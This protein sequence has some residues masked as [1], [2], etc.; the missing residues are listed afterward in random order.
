[1]RGITVL[2]I[3][4]GILVISPI[5]I[6]LL[7]IIIGLVP[8]FNIFLLNILL[9][10]LKLS[11][12]IAIIIIIIGLI[13]ILRDKIKEQNENIEYSK[14]KNIK[15]QTKNKLYFECPHCGYNKI[16]NRDKSCMVCGKKID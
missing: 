5:L 4:I 11:I 2:F 14:I 8:I 9:D 10:I 16:M 3:G 13:L 15:I 7:G 12:V 6:I 1:M